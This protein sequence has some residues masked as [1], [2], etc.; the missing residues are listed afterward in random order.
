MPVIPAPFL[1]LLLCLQP[2]PQAPWDRAAVQARIQALA[3]AKNWA[4]GADLIESL[5]APARTEL[6]Y[7]WLENLAKASRWE[8]LLAVTEELARVGHGPSRSLLVRF[9]GI[10]LSRLERHQE[11]LDLYR[12]VGRGGDITGWMEAADAATAL[13][14]WN[15][16]LECAEALVDRYPT[17][18]TY[19][20]VR[21]EAL[22]KLG[23]YAEAEPALDEAVHL[24]PKRAMS[25][26]DLACCMNERAAYAEAFEA[27]GKA[28]ALD[29]RLIE[30]WCNRG[31]ASVGLKHYKQGR[32]DYAAALALG[33][34]D[35]ALVQNL[36]MNIEAADK[37]LAYRAPKKVQGRR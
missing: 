10:A 20:G 29:P 4:G 35:P 16:L 23:R 2:A 25:W 15:A 3:A 28:V 12:E 6:A 1:P 33:P 24:E 7:S 21:G 8:R 32:D 14:D 13:A 31:R 9:K 27:A 11:A 5:P 30:G 18:G 34:K 36:K 19:L 17:N 37:Y 22:A 26:A